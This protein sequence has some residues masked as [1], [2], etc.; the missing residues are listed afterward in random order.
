MIS[1][2]RID[3]GE[4]VRQRSEKRRKRERIHAAHIRCR[5]VTARIKWPRKR[6][7]KKKSR[8]C[9][10]NGE[11]LK[12]NKVRS[13]KDDLIYLEKNKAAPKRRDAH[14]EITEGPEYEIP[15]GNESRVRMCDRGSTNL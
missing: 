5:D 11:R 13:K 1:A 4:F 14:D 6:E 3:C 15:P 9:G 10:A 2:L 7:G 8:R 12:C